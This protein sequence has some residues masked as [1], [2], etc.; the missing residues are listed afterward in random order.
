[1]S[2]SKKLPIQS[3]GSLALSATGTHLIATAGAPPAQQ[4]PWCGWERIEPQQAGA[5]AS[6][7]CSVHGSVTCLITDEAIRVDDYMDLYCPHCRLI[8]RG[9]PS[10]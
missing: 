8:P 2:H 10:A 1:L 9:R 3:G 5:F 7:V 4:C 6:F